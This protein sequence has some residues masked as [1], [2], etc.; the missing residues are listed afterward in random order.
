MSGA[1][2]IAPSDEKRIRAK[3]D[4]KWRAGEYADAG[5]LIAQ[6]EA[7]KAE[8]DAALATVGT[9]I[10]PEVIERAI[11]QHGHLGLRALDVAATWAI[12]ERKNVPVE[13]RRKTPEGSRQQTSRR[14]TSSGS[15]RDGPRRDPDD[16]DL[17]RLPA[18]VLAEPL[19]VLLRERHKKGATYD[20]L[21]EEAEIPVRRIRS[22]VNGEQERV[23]FDVADAIVSRIFGADV[24]EVE[25]AYLY[26]AAA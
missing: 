16:D 6:I 11:Q 12:A 7:V 18:R 14:R 1:L 26:G 13:P 23:S 17:I 20:D 24:W 19:A 5:S 21:A 8:R 4:A 25:L 3:F 10:P 9:P 15:G 2:A 22:I